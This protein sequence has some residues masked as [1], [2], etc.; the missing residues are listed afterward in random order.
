MNANGKIE[1]K[2]KA[3]QRVVLGV[4]LEPTRPMKGHRILS[5][6]RLPI[7]PSERDC[8]FNH[9]VFLIQKN[10]SK[11]YYLFAK[12]PFIIKLNQKSNCQNY[13]Y[14]QENNRL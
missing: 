5:P 14:E 4:G 3:K 12:L 13:E 11:I 7:P 9:Y 8:K 1:M 6:V 2:T 10:F